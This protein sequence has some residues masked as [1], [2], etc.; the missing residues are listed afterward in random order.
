MR[1]SISFVSLSR[2]ATVLM[3]LL[4]VATLTYAQITPSQDAY[5]NTAYPTTNY[6]SAVTLGVVS[7]AASIQTTYIQFDLSSIPAG[8]KSS[9]LSKATLKLYVNTVVT[10]GSFNIDFV[11]GAWT[12]KKITSSLAPAL[13]API[14]SS[15]PLTTANVKDYV[16]VDITAA[17]GAWLDGTQANDG[18]ALVANSPLSASFDSKENTAQSHPPEIDIVFS[19]TGAQG[20]PGP[21]GPQGPQG[22]MGPTGPQGP[23][24]PQGAPGMTTLTSV[25]QNFSV[26]T[27]LSCPANYVVVLASCNAGVN[28]VLNDSNSPLPPGKGN[29]LNYLTPTISGATGVHCNFNAPVSSQAQLRCANQ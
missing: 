21:Q 14:V 3:L 25:F 6:G 29:W 17:V 22:L 28:V 11:N 12:E 18:I 9:N 15:R 26:S 24:G 10:A 16:L 1:S 5:T 7:T 20:P 23:Q 4:F 27:D 19:G 13:G 2:R 8:Y